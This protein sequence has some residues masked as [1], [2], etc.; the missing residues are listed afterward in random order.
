MKLSDILCETPSAT[1]ME[2]I[3]IQLLKDTT[4]MWYP[5]D[6][7]EQG[8]DRYK[9]AILEQLKFHI[10]ELLTLQHIPMIM[11]I[12][13]LRQVGALAFY[14][15]DWP[16]L[17][18]LFDHDAA[19]KAV[20]RVMIQMLRSDAWE[21][22]DVEELLAYLKSAHITWPTLEAIEKNIGDS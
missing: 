20:V 17:K 15:R 21:T 4:G 12:R 19:R 14:G 13:I 10:D 7:I 16:E 6:Q 2:G 9:T 1:M 18:R 8:F 5:R 22:S 11:T 3:A